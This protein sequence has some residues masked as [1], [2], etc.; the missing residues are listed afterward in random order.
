MPG[1]LHAH[2][3]THHHEAWPDEC[4]KRNVPGTAF[5][6]DCLRVIQPPHKA[7]PFWGALHIVRIQVG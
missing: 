7:R 5:K 4:N 6:I 1:Q 3:H 2:T